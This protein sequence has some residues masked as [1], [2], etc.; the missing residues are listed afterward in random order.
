MAN[1]TYSDINGHRTRSTTKYGDASML[2][3]DELLRDLA[4]YADNA[5][6][7]MLNASERAAVVVRDRAKAKAP[8]L[9]EAK[10]YNKAGQSIVVP[11]GHLRDSLKVVKPRTRKG[12]YVAISRVTFGKEAAYAVPVELG[13]KLKAHGKFTGHSVEERPFMRPAADESK[14]DVI[15]MM[16]DD[17]NKTID[18][19]MKG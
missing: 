19:Y 3:L 4:D 15:D 16:I 7:D 18:K 6:P 11:P 10:T 12:V 2:G 13:H 8:V 1:Y 17:L 5:M 14:K 9:H